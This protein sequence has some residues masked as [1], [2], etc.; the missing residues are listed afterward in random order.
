MI[1]TDLDGTL[2]NSANTV[3][4]KTIQAFQTAKNQGII[5]V[6]ATGRIDCESLFFA[7][8]I[9][10]ADYLISDN[11]GVVK[12]YQNKKVIHEVALDKEI[13]REFLNLVESSDEIFCQAHTIEGC[14]CTKKTFPWMDNA[15]WAKAYVE[16]FKDKQIVVKD[17]EAYI[18]EKNIG[19]SKFVL[20]SGNYSL[21]DDIM[22]KVGKI[23]GME[24]LQP[25]DFCVECIPTGVNKGLGIIKLCDYLGVELEEVMVIGDSEND[26]EMFE[27]H[28]PVKVAMGNANTWIKEFAT[29]V[30]SSND[31]DGVAEAI[32]EFV[33][34]EIKEIKAGKE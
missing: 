16:D 15:G 30:V 32:E 1:V 18:T 3:S 23:N 34:K 22:E 5:P 33:L 9:G 6:V 25:M 27:L 20:S 13:I 28:G 8:A 7:Q 12:D 11:G 10:A 14:V 17:V 21:L 29:H 2:L 31:E 19:I 4:E 24:L 26:K